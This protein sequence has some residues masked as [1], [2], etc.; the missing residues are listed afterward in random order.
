[1]EV[2][3]VR[4]ADKGSMLT[5]SLTISDTIENYNK[6]VLATKTY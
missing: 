1:M 2:R 5:L 4:C 3:R 6:N